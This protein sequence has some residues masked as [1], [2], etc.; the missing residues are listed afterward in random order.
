MTHLQRLQLASVLA[1]GLTRRDLKLASVT[2]AD[3]SAL[4]IAANRKRNSFWVEGTG[5]DGVRRHFQMVAQVAGPPPARDR[6]PHM[7]NKWSVYENG[8]RIFRFSVS[9]SRADK[10]LGMAAAAFRA[11]G[12][13][14]T[15][16][17]QLMCDGSR[18]TKDGVI[19]MRGI[20]H[21]THFREPL[22]ATIDLR[23]KGLLHAE[24]PFNSWME[25]AFNEELPR[26][27]HFRPLMEYAAGRYMARWNRLL[28][29]VGL[30][31]DSPPEKLMDYE[32]PF[33]PKDAAECPKDSASP[34]VVGCCDV[35]TST[36]GAGIICYAATIEAS[37]IDNIGEGIVD[38]LVWAQTP[39]DSGPTDTD[40]G[41][42]ETGDTDTSDDSS[43][44][45]SPGG[46]N[47]SDPSS[48]EDWGGGD[49]GGFS[50]G[51]CFVRGTKTFTSNGPVAIETVRPGVEVWT[52][53][54]ASQKPALRQVLHAF[55]H[56]ATEIL[57]L[58]FGSETLRCTAPHRFYT[59]VWTA[60]AKLRIGQRVLSRAGKWLS[61]QGVTRITHPQPVFNLSVEGLHNY[62]V[63]RAALLVHNE[64][65]TRFPDDDTGWPDDVD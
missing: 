64:K 13:A 12:A 56:R 11:D 46:E 31:L 47:D 10:L 5:H 9:F 38:A 33:T 22:E 28:G 21:G 58:D 19:S 52:Y 59:G 37:I 35:Q 32:G 51:G 15:K 26:L 7:I 55:E 45:D 43:S 16:Y 6:F 14:A 18:A 49:E 30:N 25:E 4:F 41:D 20:H 40:T 1:P 17:L 63:G 48:G 8:R 39:S 50:G 60:A 53:D 62:F 3:G 44:E 61:L 54:A 29:L 57:I 23:K 24:T 2:A 27:Q 42:D 65:D 36:T 34:Y